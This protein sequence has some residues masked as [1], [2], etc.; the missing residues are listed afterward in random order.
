MVGALLCVPLMVGQVPGFGDADVGRLSIAAC[1]GPSSSFEDVTPMAG[2]R[3]QRC[4]RAPDDV[5]NGLHEA[6]IA[7]ALEVA[8]R[9]RRCPRIRLSQVAGG[10]DA[11][12]S[13]CRKYAHVVTRQ[14]ILPVVHTDA[15]S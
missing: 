3:H 4:P 9:A 14:S 2:E 5:R 12:R 10:H 1:A 6:K 15:L 11:E 7:K 13:D 8:S